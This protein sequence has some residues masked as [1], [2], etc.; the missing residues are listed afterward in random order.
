MLKRMGPTALRGTL[1]I[2]HEG[3]LARLFD[4]EI[5]G[6]GASKDFAT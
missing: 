6:P 2:D 5:A 1:G 4:L 3:K